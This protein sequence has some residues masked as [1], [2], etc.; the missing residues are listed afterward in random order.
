MIS[1]PFLFFGIPSEKVKDF[2]PAAIVL[3]HFFVT[4]TG[5]CH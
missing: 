2:S 1:G 5:N 3:S 4:F